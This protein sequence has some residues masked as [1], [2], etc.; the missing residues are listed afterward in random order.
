MDPKVTTRLGSH[1]LLLGHQQYLHSSEN[2]A[3]GY[4]DATI[5]LLPKDGLFCSWVVGITPTSS[6]ALPTASLQLQVHPFHNQDLSMQWIVFLVRDHPVP[7]QCPFS[8]SSLRKAMAKTG[9]KSKVLALNT[10][11]KGIPQID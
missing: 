9:V 2:S 3:C 4:K 5:S 6:P 7:T 8:S 11:F 1:T 10:D